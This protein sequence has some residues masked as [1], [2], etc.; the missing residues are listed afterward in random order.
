M[1]LY[2]HNYCVMK[3]RLLPIILLSAGVLLATSCIGF[4]SAAAKLSTNVGQDDGSVQQIVFFNPEVAPDLEEIKFPSYQAF[5]DGVTEK[6]KNQRQIKITRIDTP[7]S[8]DE[9]DTQT[10]IE[11]L[12]NNNSEIAVVPKIKYFKVGLGKYVFSNQ[13][14]VSMK[15]YDAQGNLITETSHDT[16]KKNRRIL[17]NTVNSIKL[18]TTGAITNLTKYLRKYH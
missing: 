15:L 4:S 11:I 7:L 10:I 18:G 13:V 1:A 8:Y 9:V 12:K 6:L 16:Y 5:F 3:K 2:L 14:I 17:G